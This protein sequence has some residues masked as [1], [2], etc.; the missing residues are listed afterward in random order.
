MTARS[1][2][3]CRGWRV[4]REV[5]SV[6]LPGGVLRA[7]VLQVVLAVEAVFALYML[8]GTLMGGLSDKVFDDVL[9]LRGVKEV[10][11]SIGLQSIDRIVLPA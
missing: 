9:K 10:T 8:L 2:L 6:L 7:T 3:L 11:T 4:Q 1:P 5:L